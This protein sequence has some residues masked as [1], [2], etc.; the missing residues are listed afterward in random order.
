MS[1][2]AMLLCAVQRSGKPMT[3]SD[4]HDA[5]VALAM[6]NDWP[7][8]SFA[9]WSP[10]RVAAALRNMETEHLVERA[11]VVR[12]EGN[13][14]DTWKPKGELERWSNPHFPI[15]DPPARES[16]KHQL[17]TMS[18]SQQMTAF[19]VLGEVVNAGMRLRRECDTA[20]IRAQQEFDDVVAR[21]RRQ[22]LSAG[23][24]TDP[25]REE[26]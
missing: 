24:T 5:C 23:L 1:L 19:D 22:L 20:L 21:A 11:G 10:Q 16:D 8:P 7:K 17:D 12:M 25:N 26:R 2:K 9:P 18:R 6:E 3:A 13:E 4:L 15:P 14:R